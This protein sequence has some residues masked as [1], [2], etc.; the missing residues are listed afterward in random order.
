MCITELE[1][2]GEG[3]KKLTKSNGKKKNANKDMNHWAKSVIGH[4]VE[5]DESRASHSFSQLVDV[6][7]LLLQ[8][9]TCTS[10]DLV[11]TWIKNSKIGGKL[12]LTTCKVYKKA[13]KIWV[14]AVKATVLTSYHIMCRK[15][16]A[17]ALSWFYTRESRKYPKD[18]ERDL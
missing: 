16:P 17:C 5:G 11:A 8:G 7:E 9:H 12:N 4:M 14:K 3:E 6:V 15:I 18:D 10:Q 13:R 2:G 1:H